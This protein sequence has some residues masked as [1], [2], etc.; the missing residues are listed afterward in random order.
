MKIKIK[1]RFT[2]SVIF[3]CESATI[4]R[5]V[6][7]AVAAGADLR[8]A[9]LIGANLTGANLIGADLRD[10]NL[11]D[12]NLTEI[13]DDI[14]AVLSSAPL[15]VPA[16]IFAIKSGKVDG[17]T[18]E[19]S[20][21]CLVGTLA[22]ARGK[23][24]DELDGLKPDASRPAERFFMGIKK[25]DTPETSQVSAL[26]LGWVREWLYSMVAAFGSTPVVTQ[27]N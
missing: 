27:S 1:N 24:H 15:E 16:L 10:S 5:A 18:Y 8:N 4:G 2:G 23:G 9:N 26:A 17:S 20:C 14:W 21:S 3:E 13:R 22:A 11:R 12:A 6:S 25:G 19:G 7:A